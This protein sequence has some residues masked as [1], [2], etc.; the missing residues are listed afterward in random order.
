MSKERITLERMGHIMKAVLSEIA[1]QGGAAR[2]KDIV[3]LVEPKLSLTDYEREV[4]EKSGY[5]RWIANLHFYSIE[6]VKAG[7]ITKSGG[8]WTLTEAGRKALKLPDLDFIRSAKGKYLAWK[9]KQDAEGENGEQTDETDMIVRQASYEQAQERARDER[10]SHI[11]ALSPYDFQK[12]VSEL[13]KAM[14]YHVS[15]VAPPGPD[16]GIDI[17]AYNDPLGTTTPRIK[18][19]VKHRPAT[20][21]TVKEIRE[22]RGLLNPSQDKAIFFSS[23]GFA[24]PAEKEARFATEQIELID[25]GRLIDLWCQ[26]YEHVSD[27]G[28]TLLPIVKLHFLA[29]AQE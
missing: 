28:K 27:Q 4:Y 23:G 16:G 24:S 3:P 5:V 10:E 8:K 2:V 20:K 7:Y 17:I 9:A 14:G 12:L 25:Q 6:S 26:Y 15:F 29:P 11:A 1:N 19:Q 18:V 13:L 21:V 22:I